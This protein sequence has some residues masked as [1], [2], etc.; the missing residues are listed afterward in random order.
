MRKSIIIICMGLVLTAPV[1]MANENDWT[2]FRNIVQGYRDITKLV[3]TSLALI[4]AYHPKPGTAV[5]ITSGLG[6]ADFDELAV[7]LSAVSG[8]YAYFLEV[9]TRRSGT[10]YKAMEFSYNDG[11]SGKI[12]FSPYAF[13]S[14]YSSGSL[15]KVTFNHS[16]AQREMTV[17]SQHAAA[18]NYVTRSI[19]VAREHG[20]YVDLCFTAHLDRSFS[21]A[22]TFDAYLFGARIEATTPQRCT[23][24][25]GLHDQGD[26]YDFTLFGAANTF[27]N[28]HF[29][30]TG[31]KEDGQSSDGSYPAAASVTEANLP[32]AADVIAVSVSF[33]STADPD[34]I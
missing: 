1:V 18:V 26:S 34:S 31:F 24:K 5:H 27:N 21:G 19:G 6:A 15:H 8:A 30:E 4:N 10:W 14:G 12:V 11:N 13:A 22:A 29:D 20:G 7:K 16:T 33:K 2:S 9:W 17:C 3:E 25:Q 28:G 32:S 23:A